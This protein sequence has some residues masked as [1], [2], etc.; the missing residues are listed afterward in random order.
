MYLTFP[1]LTDVVDVK[2]AMETYYT[3]WGLR[4]SIPLRFVAIQTLGIFIRGCYPKYPDFLRLDICFQLGLK[5]I[6][7]LQA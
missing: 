2:L 1:R 5:S 7:S 4:S 3:R 6:I